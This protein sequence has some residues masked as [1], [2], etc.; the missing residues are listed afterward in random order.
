MQPPLSW[1]SGGFLPIPGG[2]EVTLRPVP[3]RAVAEAVVRSLGQSDALGQTY[4]LCGPETTLRDLALDI[5][6]AMGRPATWVENSPEVIFATLPWLWFTLKKPILFPV[7]LKLCRLFASVA[8]RILPNP[9]LTTDQILML[10]E[11]QVGDSSPAA[12][13]LGF[14]PG[15]LPQGLAAYLAPREGGRADLRL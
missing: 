13:M 9:P 2:S 15:P 10:E 7:P 8:E 1:L 14:H 5:A 12:R 4:D 6:C 3:V 11:G